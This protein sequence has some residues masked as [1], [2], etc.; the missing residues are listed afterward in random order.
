MALFRQIPFEPVAD[1]PADDT[2]RIQIDDH[3]KIEPTLCRPEI[4]DVTGPFLV[5]PRGLKISIQKVLC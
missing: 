1:G 4:A 5:W 2:A 3:R